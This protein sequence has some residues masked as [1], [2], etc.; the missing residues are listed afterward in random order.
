MIDWGVQ[1]TSFVWYLGPILI[2]NQ[3]LDFE[4][5][6]LA[7]VG[8]L[9]GRKIIHKHIVFCHMQQNTTQL[10]VPKKVQNKSR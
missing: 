2:H 10:Q 1:I 5:V 7:V 9:K 6:I 3:W 8:W 4:G